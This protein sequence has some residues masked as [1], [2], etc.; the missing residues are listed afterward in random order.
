[1]QNF[2]MRLSLVAA[3]MSVGIASSGCVS[4]SLPHLPKHTQVSRIMDSLRESHPDGIPAGAAQEK[5]QQC[6]FKCQM[7][8]NGTFVHKVHEPTDGKLQRRELQDIDFIE[9]HRK[10]QSGLVT[11]FDT[12]A[13]IVEGDIVTEVLSHWEATGL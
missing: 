4:S 13:L 7:V 9:C 12:V 1:M 11:Y 8:Q 3:A 5:M 6:G 2:Q 10:R